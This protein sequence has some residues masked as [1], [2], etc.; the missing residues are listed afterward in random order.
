MQAL[1]KPISPTQ[2]FPQHKQPKILAAMRLIQHPIVT[3]TILIQASHANSIQIAGVST[4]AI[5]VA[6]HI[7]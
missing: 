2:F 4:R 7:I 1:E 6:D 5:N 3:V